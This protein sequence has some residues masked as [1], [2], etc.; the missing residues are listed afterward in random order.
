LYVL[1]AATN[2]LP[3]PEPRSIKTLLGVNETCFNISRLR[4]GGVW[5]GGEPPRM[6]IILETPQSAKP[7]TNKIKIE[8][9]SVCTRDMVI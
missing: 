2:I 8:R 3:V 1:A 5:T 9:I 4:A 6:A 7:S